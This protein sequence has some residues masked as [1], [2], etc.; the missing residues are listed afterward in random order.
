MRHKKSKNRLNRYTSWRTATIKSLARSIII[1]QS[2]RTTKARAK[3]VQPMIEKLIGLGKLNTLAA[4]RRAFSLLSD[5]SLVSLLFGEIAPRFSNRTGGYS[6]I[7]IL[8]PRRGDNA[9]TVLFELT[10]I[11]KKEHKKIKKEKAAERPEGPHKAQEETVEEK[12]HTATAVEEKV[13]RHEDKKAPKK[14]LGGI[15]NIF[16]KERDSL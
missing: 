1:N 13:H 3:A 9:E 15:R 6:R 12:P 5:H 16:K 2:I 11:K 4:K 8:G 10:E 7:I 14:F